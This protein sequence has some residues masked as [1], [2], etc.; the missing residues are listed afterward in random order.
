MQEKILDIKAGDGQ[1][2]QMRRADIF[3]KVYLYNADY[4]NI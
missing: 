1:N 4:Y 3:L 2:T